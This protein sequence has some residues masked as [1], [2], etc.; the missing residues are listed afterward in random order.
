LPLLLLGFVA[1]VMAVV[2][3]GFGPPALVE[4][5]TL[6]AMQNAQA[7]QTIFSQPFDIKANRNVR[8]TANAA[9]SNA[10]ADLDVDLIND[11]SQEVESVNVPIEYYSGTDSDGA[12]TEGSQSTDA[13]LSSLPAGKYTL[14][15]E[16]TWQN[17][18]QPI[19]VN[20]KVEQGVNRGVKFCCAII[21]L[22]IVPLFGLIRKWSFE[23][24]RW[25]DSM[26]GSTAGSDDDE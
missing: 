13:T 10:W 17:W 4:Q 24:S 7:P 1:I 26:F 11:Q 5:I 6:P 3:G 22:A 8:I 21:A 15:V 23:A 9:V 2:A 16:G 14:R 18:Q 19:A 25:K 12:W 20:V